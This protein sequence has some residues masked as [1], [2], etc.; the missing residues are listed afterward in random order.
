LTGRRAEARHVVD[1][2]LLG[3]PEQS[4]FE[5]LSLGDKDVF[6]RDVVCGE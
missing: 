1:Q 3:E 6:V 4:L 2:E 5:V